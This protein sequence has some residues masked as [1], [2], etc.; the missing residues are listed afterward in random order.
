MKVLVAE[1][2]QEGRYLLEKMLEGYGHEVI[3]ASNGAEALEKALVQ[4]PDII[5]SDILMPKMDGFQLCHECKRNEKL[6]RV[7]FVFYTA[8]YTS[9]EDEK[10]ALS[11]GADIFIR[12]PTEPDILVQMLFKVFEKAK[13]PRLSSV[14]IVSLEPS[15]YLTEYNKRIVAKLEEKVAALEIEITRRKKAE[16]KLKEYSENLEN[17][18][19]Q[20]TKKLKNAQEKLV[21]KEKLAIL[22]QMAGSVSHEIRNPL[23]VISNAIYYLKMIL[24]E[25]NKEVKEYLEMISEEVKASEKII[26]DLLDLSRSKSTKK[27]KIAISSLIS[28]LLEKSPSPKGIELIRKISPDT[29]F[30]FVDS[31]QIK[32]VLG[33]LITNSYQAMPEGGKLTIK[34]EANKG[35]VLVSLIDTGC[36]IPTK[37]M[38]KL[39]EPLFTTKAKGVGL[40]L[41]I[42]KDLTELNEGK[43]K[44]ESREGEGTTFTLIFNK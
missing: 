29:L 42:A 20:R 19:A 39:F 30:L 43:I 35:K 3:V 1:D 5:I 4:L 22:G 44:V 16:K 18:V 15:L 40:G 27:E 41:T 31:Q 2:S 23:G 21:H 37:N 32:Q 14:G 6:K 7:P 38:K 33:N 11:I 25:A 8:D 9:D 13:S 36:G 17:I 10:F 28:Q 24:P 26:S 12:K 34:A